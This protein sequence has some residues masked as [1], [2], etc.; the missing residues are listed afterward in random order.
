MTSNIFGFHN[1]AMDEGAYFFDAEDN[2][3]QFNRRLPPSVNQRTRRRDQDQT[4]NYYNN[5]QTSSNILTNN[6][7]QCNLNQN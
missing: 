3:L 2:V 5:Q 1:N 4:I 7:E 6:R